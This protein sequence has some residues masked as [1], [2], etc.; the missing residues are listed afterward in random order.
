MGLKLDELQPPIPPPK[1]TIDYSFEASEYE[2]KLIQVILSQIEF[3][4]IL[5]TVIDVQRTCRMAIWGQPEAC[6][7]SGG[8]PTIMKSGWG[9]FT[10]TVI[11]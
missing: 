2:K 10:C 11:F 4:L 8:C 1:S 6:H 5:L 9:S 7:G 3:N